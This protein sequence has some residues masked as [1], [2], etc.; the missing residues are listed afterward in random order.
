MLSSMGE[1]T[2][3]SWFIPLLEDVVAVGCIIEETG[4]VWDAGTRVGPKFKFPPKSANE[5]PCKGA[6]F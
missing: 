4:G 5:I 6:G 3:E 2:S 1:N